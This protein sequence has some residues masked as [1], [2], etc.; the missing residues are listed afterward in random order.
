VGTSRSR[1][2]GITNALPSTSRSAPPT[3]KFHSLPTSFSSNAAF[4]DE[5]KGY[6]SM[7]PTSSN[8]T[9]STSTG[10]QIPYKNRTSRSRKRSRQEEEELDAELER[11]RE[12]ERERDKDRD[13]VREREGGLSSRS[14]NSS[15]GRGAIERERERGVSRWDRGS[16]RSQSSNASTVSTIGV[17]A[18]RLNGILNSNDGGSKS[19][20]LL[21]PPPVRLPQFKSLIAPLL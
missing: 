2:E 10:F 1:L 17:S 3:P 6:N 11:E 20:V 18:K 14:R 5:K 19:L 9:I 4:S 12:R 7:L 21:P 8:G 16:D 13:R 15:P